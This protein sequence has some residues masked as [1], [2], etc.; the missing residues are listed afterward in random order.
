MRQ[1]VAELVLLAAFLVASPMALADE[2]SV[3]QTS[4][5]SPQELLKQIDAEGARTVVHRLWG[6]SDPESDVFDK[7]CDA[8]ESADPS[9]RSCSSTQAWV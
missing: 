4:V 5:P 8:I 9:C 1:L 3:A 2:H 7:V 6:Q